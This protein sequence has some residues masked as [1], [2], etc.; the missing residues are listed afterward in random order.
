M[1]DSDWRI[2]QKMMTVNTNEHA[3]EWDGVDENSCLVENFSWR[4]LVCHCITTETKVSREKQQD[5]LLGRLITHAQKLSNDTT[6]PVIPI[7]PGLKISHWIHSDKSSF[8]WRNCTGTFFNR[9]GLEGGKKKP[10]SE[11]AI[12]YG[13]IHSFEMSPNWYIW[14][15]SSEYKQ[16]FQT[17]H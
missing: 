14:P 7:S 5:P 3:I 8:Q 17:R 13:L 11:N 4:N 9:I 2:I 16:E 12:R 1:N 10:K 6:L 15:R